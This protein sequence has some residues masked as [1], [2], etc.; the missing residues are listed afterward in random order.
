MA[1]FDNDR[2]RGFVMLEDN[3]RHVFT[4][5][6]WRDLFATWRDEVSKKHAAGIPIG[7]ELRE[8]RVLLERTLRESDRGD[9]ADRVALTALLEQLGSEESESAVLHRMLAQETATLL[10]RVEFAATFRVTSASWTWSSTAGPP[11]SAP[12][13]SVPALDVQRPR[14]PRAP[15]TTS[16][17]AA[18]CA[19]PRLRRALFPADPPDRP[20]LPQGQEQQPDPRPG[21]SRQPLCD[22]L[23][24]GGHDAIHPELGPSTIFAR[25]VRQRASH[26]LEIALDFAIPVLAGPSLDQGAPEWFEWRPDGT[27]RYA[28]NPPKKYEDIVHVHFYD[29]ALPQVWYAFRDIFLFWVDKGVKIFRVDNPHTKPVPFWEWVI[30][31]VQDR[32]PDVIFLAEAFTRPKMMKRLAKVG[33]PQSYSYFTW[34]NTKAELTQYLTELTGTECRHYMRPNFFVNTPDI[35]PLYLQTSGRPGFRTRLVLAATLAG[36]YGVYNGYELCEAAPMPGKEE[37]LDSEKYEIKGARLGH[38]GAHQAGHP[39]GQ[40]AAP[41]PPRPAT[42]H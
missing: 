33:F 41:R 1:Y 11:L 25:L 12:G 39:P 34:R 38:A 16:S 18:L 23:P 20:R 21:R 40:P 42:F 4:V 3:A 32:H 27:I 13:T 19:R 37:Y 26:G 14:P 15:S 8:G 30:R 28:E 29:E 6:A 35:N 22:R 31:E 2:W 9:Q 10:K 17:P 5:I 36:N 7:L 24:G